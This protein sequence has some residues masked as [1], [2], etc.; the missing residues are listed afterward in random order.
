MESDELI[1]PALG[2]AFGEGLTRRFETGSAT[3]VIERDDGMVEVDPFDYFSPPEG[4]HWEWI[5]SRL[6]HRVLDV[7][8]GAGRACL[9]LQALGHDVVGLDVSPGAVQVATSRGVSQTFLG[10]VEDL[11]A[12]DPAPFDSFVGLGNNLGLLADPER[13]VTFLET[14]G[15]MSHAGSNLVGTILDPY[16]TEEPL[17]LAYHE[18]NRRAGRL[19]GEVRIRVRHRRTATAWFGLL[20]CSP[21]ELAEVIRPADWVL[22]ATQGEGI[23]AAELGQNGS[24]ASE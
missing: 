10:T 22:A 6:G 24:A 19:A 2:D 13:A 16:D 20:W 7:G 14:L 21:E 5:R 11:A 8:C 3:I 12:T 23:Y 9:A 4:P 15:R 17:H 1:G 18:A